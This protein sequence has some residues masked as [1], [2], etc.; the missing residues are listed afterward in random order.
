MKS[1]IISRVRERSGKIARLQAVEHYLEVM[2]I[3]GEYHGSG[4]CTV[5][6]LVLEMIIG[7]SGDTCELA[8]PLP[9][10]RRV[11]VEVRIT[12]LEDDPS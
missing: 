8:F 11:N 5:R 2:G 12:K 7:K 6:E 3:D 4:F 9:D 1:K 10:G